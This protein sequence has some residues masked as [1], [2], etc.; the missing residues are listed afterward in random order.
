MAERAA[1]LDLV[2]NFKAALKRKG[3][4]SESD[5]SIAYPSNRGRKLKHRARFVRE[6]QLDAPTGPRVYKEEVEFGGA[7]RYIIRRHKRVRRE[8]E[9]EEESEGDSEDTID[10]EDPFESVD[11]EKILAPVNN[12]A[13]LPSHPT[14]SLPYTSRI[15]DQLCQQALEIIQPEHEHTTA[16]KNLLTTFLGDDEFA[17]LGKLEK[18]EMPEFMKKALE[19]Q[20]QKETTNGTSDTTKPNG[21]TQKTTQT[22]EKATS[23]GRASQSPETGKSKE[24]MELDTEDDE[25]DGHTPPPPTRMTTR[26]HNAQQQQQQQAAG[27]SSASP[28]AS[29]RLEIESFFFPPDF[30]VDRDFGIPASEADE[31]RRL[32]LAAVQRQEEFMRGLN[33]V[34]AG[35]LQAKHRK[36]EVWRWCR[37]MEGVREYQAAKTGRDVADIPEDE[38]LGPLSDHEDW[39]DRAEWGLEQDLIK[40]KEEEEEEE[41]TKKTTRGRRA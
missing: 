13:D 25:Q 36:E 27:A 33:K 26:S 35:L 20:N 11:I 9:D 1:L 6:G 30:S 14:L 24:A 15:L 19:A 16:I 4:E 2:T 39:Y 34:H 7:R 18:C 41:K 10:E 5:D 31:T 21:H 40:G 17:S 29:P 8:E 38:P 22:E 12:P 3:D 37:A 32:L 28:P 23:Q